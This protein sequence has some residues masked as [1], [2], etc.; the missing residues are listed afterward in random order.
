MVTARR[1]EE[2]IQDVPIAITA[3]PAQE[4]FDRGAADLRDLQYSIPGLNIVSLS[5]GADRII[6]RG[7]DPGSGTGLPIV[8]IYVDDV[9]ISVDQQ[10]RDPPFPLVDIARVEVL[11]GPQGTT[12]G[13]GSVAG[14]IR[15][16]TQ[17]PNLQRATGYALGNVYSQQ[18]G[19]VGYRVNGAVGVPLIE[20]KLGLRLVGGHERYAGWIDYTVPKI[21]DANRVERTFGRARLL[22]Q[23]TPA[24]R[25][26]LMYQYVDQ[27]TDTNNLS[28]LNSNTINSKLPSLAPSSDKSHLINLSVD[29]DIGGVTLTSATGYQHRHNLIVGVIP[30]PP[31]VINFDTVY[32]QFSQEVRLASNDASAPISWVVGAWYRDFDSEV[33]RTATIF[34][35][36]FPPLA[37]QGDD[38]VDSESKAVF[39]D[40]TWRPSPKLELSGGLRYYW[41]TR[42]SAGRSNGTA[43]PT[44]RASFDAFSPRVNMLYRFTDSISVYATAAKGFRSGGFNGGSGSAY[45]PEKLWSYEVGTKAALLDNRLF[46]EL[47]GYY[48]DYKNRQSQGVVLINGVNFTETTNG[49]KASG[50]GI[51]GAL[52]ARLP[53]G[54]GIDLTA[55]YNKVE[56]DRT[57]Q[58][59]NSG[60]PFDYVPKF[61]ASASLHQRIALS[62]RTAA[63]WRADYQ[64]A[65]SSFSITRAN[66]CSAATGICMPGTTTENYKLA[67]QD[68]VNLRAGVQFGQF[69]LS[70]DVFNVFN[71]D[72]ETFLFSPV[73]VFDQA[74]RIRPRSYGLT[75]R[76]N[77]D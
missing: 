1:R 27:K 7:V 37:R 65:S 60:E 38:P 24:G 20:D 74:T 73:A 32:K 39:G 23:P 75:L 41:D 2:R 35:G 77:F 47:A 40:A 54:F 76:V 62:E 58:D 49:G 55:A 8:G 29:V 64:H 14:T 18:H 44:S 69:D 36:P 53:A 33:D 11:R 16:I 21:E 67:P 63:Y 51:E 31:I 28:D 68:L 50:P 70:A 56:Y 34:G 71:E 9:G 17:E 59:T 22:W 13:Q 52:T 10:Q 5:P 48:V 42:E 30:S 26:S 43:L 12:Y 45:G 6:L 72:A 61:T 57:T 46:F 66:T 25:V 3:V 19:E 4:I 15:Y